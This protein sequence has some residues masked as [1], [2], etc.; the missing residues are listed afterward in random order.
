M[1]LV[2]VLRQ[3]SREGAR[4]ATLVYTIFDGSG[5]WRG[6]SDA[7]EDGGKYRELD[8]VFHQGVVVVAG[9]YGV[10]AGPNTG[11]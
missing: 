2:R 3:C 10:M 9:Y 8:A 1:Q 5:V 11:D 4:V 7:R 6:V